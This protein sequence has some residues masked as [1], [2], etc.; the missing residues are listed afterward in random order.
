MEGIRG[1]CTLGC[2][3]ELPSVKVFSIHKEQNAKPTRWH[4][5]HRGYRKV[6]QRRRGD[7]HV[8]CV[9]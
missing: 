5:V 1:R 9:C 4:C 3:E 6:I 2:H 7:K 8:Q